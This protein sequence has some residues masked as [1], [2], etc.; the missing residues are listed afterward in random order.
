LRYLI[1]VNLCILGKMNIS[2]YLQ[3][4]LI[5]LE[6]D[7][8]V[9]PPMNETYSKK[10]YL[11]IKETILHELADLLDLSGKVSNRRKLF[12]DLLNRE[13]KASTAIGK[14]I[15]IPHIRSMQA[16]DLIIAIG[17]NSDGYEFE[18]MDDEPVKLFFCMAAPPY[19][20]SLYLKV[21]KELAERFEYPG[22]I[23]KLLSAEN[24]HEIIRIFQEYEQ[25]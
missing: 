18:A 25:G 22:F 12:I 24:G 9:E 8:V 15:A 3:F 6:M 13:K 2:K 20:D 7:S 5:K 21:F 14:N 10:E 1:R 11:V 23:D 4:E 17:R 16:R 19:D